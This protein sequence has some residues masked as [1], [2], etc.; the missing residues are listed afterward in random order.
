MSQLTNEQRAVVE[1]RA[2]LLAVDAFAGSGKTSTLIQYARARPR[3]RIL[4]LAFNKSV[5]TGARDRFPSNVDCRTTHSLAYAAEG[6]KYTDK[7]GNPQAYEVAQECRCNPRRAKV[8]LSTISSWLCSSDDKI[9]TAHVDPESVEDDTDAA[10]V[11]DQSRGVW[12]KMMDLRSALKLPHDGYLKLWAM[13]KPRLRYDILLLDEAQDTNALTLD[14][15]LRQRGH[16]T[17]VLVGDRHQGIYGFRKA[18]NA[19]ELVD[20][21][22]RIALTQSFRFAHGIADVATRLLA[23]FKGEKQGV[24]GR[25]DI[26]VEWA[27]DTGRHYAVISRTNAGLFE[28][29]AREVQAWAECRLHF[30]GGFESY[31]FGKV[32]D[33]YH[34]W[35]DE[36]PKIKDASIARFAKWVDFERYGEEAGDSEVKA[37]VKVVETYGSQIPTLYAAIKEADA[38]VQERAHLTLTTAHKAKGLEWE[39]VYLTDD[40]IDLEDLPEDFDP[41]EIN[42][43]YVAL[44]RAVRAARLTDSLATWL[45]SI[46]IHGPAAA[47]QMARTPTSAAMAPVASVPRDGKQAMQLWLATH[48]HRLSEQTVK[49]LSALLGELETLDSPATR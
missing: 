7:L 44:T 37:L 48:A 16:A 1:S 6:R 3:A 12:A 42:L 47:R 39:Q 4:Y 27:V 21:D 25:D 33:A 41:E 8:I 34:L 28:S 49:E 18:L 22:E 17:I 13:S 24:K 11:V 5:A 38:P 2:A 26:E 43:L 29:A 15:V 46:G 9:R 40:F 23:A 10:A 14:L 30:I 35:T 19:M 45:D 36:R 32:I 20:A 31:L